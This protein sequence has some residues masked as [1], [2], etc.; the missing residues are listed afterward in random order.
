MTQISLKSAWIQSKKTDTMLP[1]TWFSARRTG[2]WGLGWPSQQLT[3]PGLRPLEWGLHPEPWGH[4]PPCLHNLKT[5]VNTED[6]KHHLWGFF[7]HPS[8]LFKADSQRPWKSDCVIWTDSES[9]FL[10]CRNTCNIDLPTLKHADKQVTKIRTVY[11]ISCEWTRCNHKKNGP[12]QSVTL[13]NNSMFVVYFYKC[14]NKQVALWWYS[15][16]RSN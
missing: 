16:A 12:F 2:W 11:M 1:E 3:Q 9:Y 14:S 4:S 7:A 13:L 5:P 10:W 8:V 15:K 6:R